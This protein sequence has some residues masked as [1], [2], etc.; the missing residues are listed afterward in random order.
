MEDFK[1]ILLVGG[2]GFIGSELVKKLAENDLDITVIYIGGLAESEKIKDVEYRQIDL[3]QDSDGAKE[4][5]AKADC[6]VLMAQP[7]E[8]LMKNFLNLVK[9]SEVKKVVYT[10]TMLLYP[11][12]L[13]LQDE[14]VNLEPMNDYENKKYSEESMLKEFANQK[15]KVCIARLGN[16]YGDKKNRGI[17]NYI[18]KAL[19]NSET[20]SISGDGEHKRDYIFVRDV[21]DALE[22][23]I[24]IDQEN[25]LEIYNIC[26]GKSYS[27]NELIGELEKISGKKII[28]ENKSPIVEKRSVIGDNKK[29]KEKINFEI[30]FDIIKGLTEAYKNYLS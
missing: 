20:L 4:I 9:D 10:S 22:Q 11:D 17:V 5:I 18:I 19:E 21:V 13:E 1:N 14:S 24:L 6:A 30:K 16:V 23:L 12:S 27:I 2:T 25:N 15:T 29:I 7:D 26:S 28:K 3:S 8:A